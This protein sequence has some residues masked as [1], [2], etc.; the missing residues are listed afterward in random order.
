MSGQD[1]SQDKQYLIC[2]LCTKAGGLK[3]YR[4]DSLDGARLMRDHILREHPVVME[5]GDEKALMEF[6]LKLE[7]QRMMEIKSTAG[8]EGI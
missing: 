8:K 1:K 2:V 6:E 3:T 4:E 5:D 7:T